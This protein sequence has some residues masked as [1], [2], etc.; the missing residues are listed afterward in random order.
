MFGVIFEFNMEVLPS[1]LLGG[2][3]ALN[4]DCGE[5]RRRNVTHVVS[6][7]SAEQRR[8]PEF[9]RGHLHIHSFDSEDAALK[10]AE[11]F[12]EICRF[13]DAAVNDHGVVYVHC[14][15]GISRAPTATASYIMW[16]LGLSAPVALRLIR[17]ARPCVR[18]NLG[19]ARELRKWEKTMEELD[20][21]PWGEL[22]QQGA[23][24]MMRQGQRCARDWSVDLSKV[25]LRAANRASCISSAQAFALGGRPKQEPVEPLRQEP[26]EVLLQRG[27]A[28]LPQ[29]SP[30]TAEVRSPEL[31][32]EIRQNLGLEGRMFG[33][34]QGFP[35]IT[36]TKHFGAY[37][38]THGYIG[39]VMALDRHGPHA[40]HGDDFVII[41]AP[42]VGYD[43]E[44]ETY[45]VYRRSVDPA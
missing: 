26:V 41:H 43:P 39:G 42:H 12:P 31:A 4:Q 9:I 11:R 15:A 32:Q 45:G 37:P 22:T 14:G 8:L 19:F 29:Q 33:G 23:D 44:T 2:W 38:F 17:A 21:F 10:L 20:G 27:E 16:K 1:L 36:I 6:I 35:A 24:E 13:I 34:N 25:L 18:P 5:L 3:A 30:E 40:H 7:V 28:L